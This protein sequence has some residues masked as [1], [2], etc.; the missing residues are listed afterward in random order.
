MP[1]LAEAAKPILG[2]FLST[3]VSVMVF[4]AVRAA[5]AGG[6]LSLVS[7]MIVA[8][9]LNIRHLASLNCD[10]LLPTSLPSVGE[11]SS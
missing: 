7:A 3:A 8:G 1:R 10:A 5:G 4:F 6:D 9:L 2:A 11:L